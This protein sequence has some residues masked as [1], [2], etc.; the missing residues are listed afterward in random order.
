LS[1]DFFIEGDEVALTA[2]G[3]PPGAATPAAFG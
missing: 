3:E 2:P 1:R